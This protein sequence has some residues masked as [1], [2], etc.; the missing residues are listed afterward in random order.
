MEIEGGLRVHNAPGPL[1][2]FEL[3]APEPSSRSLG[4]DVPW[5]S[6]FEFQEGSSAQTLGI[7]HAPRAD[8]AGARVFQRCCSCRKAVNTQSGVE[9]VSIG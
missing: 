5:N 8:A 3:Q 9:T 1:V 4:S 7:L 2:R 6:E